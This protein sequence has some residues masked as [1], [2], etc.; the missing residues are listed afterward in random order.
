M[1][2]TDSA[3]PDRGETA[4]PAVSILQNTERVANVITTTLPKTKPSFTIARPN[5]GIPAHM[6][7]TSQQKDISSKFR[8]MHRI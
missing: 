6:Y 8:C 7:N 3:D 2:Q 5:L 1:L 4:T